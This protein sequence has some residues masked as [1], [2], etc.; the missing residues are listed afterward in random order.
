M[1]TKNDCTM[2]P[3]PSTNEFVQP[4]THPDFSS[5]STSQSVPSVDPGQHQMITKVP[6][7]AVCLMKGDGLHY[8]VFTCNACKV[9][10]IH[11]MI[12]WLFL[13]K[14]RLLCEHSKKELL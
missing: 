3:L 2:A 4:S 9:S 8:G 12:V 5:P 6:P 11:Y 7:C 14:Q 13:L 10:T 1:S